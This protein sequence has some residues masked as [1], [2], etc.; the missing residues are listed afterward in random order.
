V[1]AA[2]VIPARLAYTNV[3]AVKTFVVELCLIERLSRH[4]EIGALKAQ[5]YM[6]AWDGTTTSRRAG[7]ASVIINVGD[8]WASVPVGDRRNRMIQR[9]LTEAKAFAKGFPVDQDR[10]PG[11]R[12]LSDTT[13]FLAINYVNSG[14][15]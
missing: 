2:A 10:K 5:P 8:S 11:D 15:V 3:A 9:R 12:R 1:P 13:V 6:S 7:L 4:E 14:L